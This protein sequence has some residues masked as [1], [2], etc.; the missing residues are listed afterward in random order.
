VSNRIVFGSGSPSTA[1]RSQVIL[2][3]VTQFD[4]NLTL[5]V[6]AQVFGKYA[7]A[8]ETNNSIFCA[9][10]TLGVTDTAVTVPFTVNR[11]TIGSPQRAGHIRSIIYYP[12]RLSNTE[13]QSITT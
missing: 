5:Q 3:G 1:A 10:G 8:F 4:S 2:G 7:V 6:T 12:T 13:L 11:L 9:N